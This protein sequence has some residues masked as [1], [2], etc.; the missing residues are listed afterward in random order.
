MTLATTLP[1][2]ANCC[3]ASPRQGADSWFGDYFG[4]ALP[5]G[6]RQQANAMSWETF[7]AAYGH[8]AGPLRLGHWACTDGRGGRPP[9]GHKPA[10]SA[11]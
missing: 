4:V 9:A 10:T 6:L 3:P 5:H 2:Q 1:A 11:R 8:T 7:V